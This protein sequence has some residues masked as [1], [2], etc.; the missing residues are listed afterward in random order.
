MPC[1]NFSARL[2]DTNSAQYRKWLTPEQFGAQ[3]GVSD[4]DIQTVSTWLASQGFKVNKVNKAHTII[5]FSGS[6]GQVQTAFHTQI[7][8]FTVNG[9]QHLANVSDPQIP[10][11][12][13]PVVAGL[14]SLNNFFP[15][16]QHTKPQLGQ[17]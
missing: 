3:Y 4:A 14:S 12:L 2:Q 7:H 9:E 16:P 13:A 1:G 5:E 17:V 10:A 8:N 15:K 6:I 11:A